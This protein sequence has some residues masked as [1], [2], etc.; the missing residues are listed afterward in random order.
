MTWVLLL[1]HFISEETE[2][3]KMKQLDLKVTL[4]KAELG[5]K[6]RKS[7]F[8]GHA[9]GL[10][11]PVW[12]KVVLDFFSVPSTPEPGILVLCPW[13]E[14]NVSPNGDKMGMESTQEVKEQEVG[15]TPVSWCG[16]QGGETRR[17]FK[18]GDLDFLGDNLHFGQVEFEGLIR[19][20]R[21]HNKGQLNISIVRTPSSNFLSVRKLLWPPQTDFHIFLSLT[22]TPVTA[23]SP[24]CLSP[25]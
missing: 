8:T 6:P 23:S 13:Q 10:L 22:C 11:L 1:F 17:R 2:V 15:A 18:R 7:A 16:Q 25:P 24:F 3:L 19:R 21:R 4:V 5:F 12:R 20:P 14:G 9:F